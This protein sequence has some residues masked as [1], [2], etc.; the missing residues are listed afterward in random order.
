MPPYS[1]THK[2][3]DETCRVNGNTDLDAAA[4]GTKFDGRRWTGS[5]QYRCNHYPDGRTR[6]FLRHARIGYRLGSSRNH[7]G[8]E[9]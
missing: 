2:D 5:L 8:P 4:V 3:C 1:R 7:R 9:L 6:H